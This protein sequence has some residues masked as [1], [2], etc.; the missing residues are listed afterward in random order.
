MTLR[1]KTLSIIALTIAGLVA[2]VYVPTRSLFLNSFSKLETLAAAEKVRQGLHAIERELDAL[3]TL[4]LD[5]GG[6]DD[7]YQFAEDLTTGNSAGIKRYVDSNL[8][9]ATFIDDRLLLIAVIP[10]AREAAYMHAFD[11]E[12]R[13]AV[14]PPDLPKLIEAYPQLVD[15]DAPGSSTLG[16]I[17]LRGEPVLVASRPILTSR[18]TG[19]VRGSLIM[20]RPLDVEQIR[21]VTLSPVRLERADG[22]ALPPDFAEAEAAL[23][24]SDEPYIRTLRADTVAGY[25][26]IRDVRGV[27]ILAMRLDL[28]R[29]IYSSGR[30]GARWIMAYLLG[31]S[32]VFALVTLLLLE[33][34]VLRR[35]RRLSEAVTSIGSG[36]GL[37]EPIILGGDDEVS[38]LAAAINRTV[39]SLQRSQGALRYIGAQARCII[40]SAAVRKD[41]R[42][43]YRWT[44]HMQDEQAA[45]RVLPLDIFRGGSYANAWMRSRHPD[46][47][48]RVEERANVAIEAGRS[49]YNH[50][51]RVRGKDRKD[52]WVWEE[53][54][55]ENVEPDHWELVGVCTDITARKSAEQQMMEAR[56]AALE[57]ARLKSEFL[58]NM[59]HEI[60]TPMNGI[61]GMA[62]LL[63]D[64]GPS[65]EQREYL[66]LIKQSADTLLRL[67]NDIL[68]FSKIEADRLEIESQP[69]H[70]R[71]SLSDAM[72]LLAVR[73]HAK[74]LELLL[75]VDP[76]IPDLVMGDEA[77]IQQ[78]IINLLGNAIKFTES[79][80]VELGV[81][82]EPAGERQLF[83]HLTV[84]DTGIGISE[85][86]QERVFQAFQQA[87]SSTTRRYGGSGLGLAISSQL[88]RRM[89]GRMW[90][91]SELGRG[92]TF[93]ATVLVEL[94]TA[95]AQ[96]DFDLPAH[97]KDQAVLVIDDNA[98]SREIIE[99]MLEHRGIRSTLVP[100]AAVARDLLAGEAKCPFGLILCDAVMPDVDGFELAAA[101]SARGLD[102]RRLIMMLLSTDL[103]RDASRCRQLGVGGYITKPVPEADL[104]NRLL[105]VHGERPSGEPVEATLEA[106]VPGRG[107]VLNILLAEDN[108]INQQVAERI[109]SR[110]GHTVTVVEDGRQAVEA[111]RRAGGHPFDLVL[112]DVQMPSMGGLDA[113]R[114]I[115]R[116]LD[117]PACDVPIIAMTAHALKGDRKRCLQ[118]GMSGY[119]AK[120]ISPEDLFDE[121]HRLLPAV[122]RSPDEGPASRA[123]LRRLNAETIVARL[124][125]DRQLL[126]ELI[127]LFRQQS[128]ALLSELSAAAAAGSLRDVQRLSH[129]LKGSVSTFDA[130]EAVTS[131]EALEAAADAGDA[132]L[133]ERLLPQIERRLT[134]LAED[135]R[136]YS[137]GRT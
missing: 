83:L 6:W 64:T 8:V 16:L 12:E 50:E 39:E 90:V 102:P 55:I 5:Y 38:N 98:R 23:L 122:A 19:P 73:A 70:L 109:L 130:D 76:K 57:A 135:L 10:S 69:F 79:G 62:D 115:R 108:P 124:G 97:L 85:Q 112:M 91:E 63:M 133:V 65:S 105:R 41:K 131:L 14:A 96:S 15:H 103:S 94:S 107:T 61:V 9:D 67:I 87:D 74:G 40:W 27:P 60:R 1:T 34:V 86:E 84:R 100:S 54:A 22:P 59:S 17:E 134:Q 25:A 53:V 26:L 56:D 49:S 4:A 31:S 43:H 44:L 2:I 36:G 11:L 18:K 35:M 89:H 66:G 29:N 125:G 20:A 47:L 45:Q 136:A 7:T 116:D 37:S 80:E 71:R 81:I 52:H 30:A 42:G 121:I 110:R 99:Q 51:Y 82:G 58:A 126:L 75:Q 101:L 28:P 111:L 32:L 132:R 77:R 68:D 92:S 33:H 114:V 117:P 46:D 93:H 48:S 3:D 127:E 128:P 119:V 104:L 123:S 120:P 88:A 95:S 21:D 78:I 24:Q 113:T 129:T 72:A 118:A 106:E 13:R 137:E